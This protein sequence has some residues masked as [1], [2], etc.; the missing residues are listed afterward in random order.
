MYQLTGPQAVYRPKDINLNANPGTPW[1][2]QSV[3]VVREKDSRVPRERE[4]GAGAI[5]LSLGSGT[6]ALVITIQK[7]KIFDFPGWCCG[8][9]RKGLPVGFRATP[10]RN[11]G[12]MISG[13]KIM[14]LQ[15]AI[16]RMGRDR[17]HGGRAIQ[18]SPV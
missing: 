7:E 12:W 9:R 8:I 3:F 5:H 17:G 16:A 10:P 18:S 2:H 4:R 6:E 11:A 14:C 1:I 13:R 15:S